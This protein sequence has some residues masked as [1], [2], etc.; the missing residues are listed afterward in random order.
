MSNKATIY[1]VSTDD[2]KEGVRRCLSNI[3]P[4]DY[5]GKTLFVKP[6]FNT[7]DITP[8]SSHNDTIEALLIGLKAARPLSITLGDRSGPAD[9]GDVMRQKEMPELCAKYGVKLVNFEELK[10]DEWV[11]FN[12]E[13]L[14][15]PYGFEMPKLVLESDVIIA[16]CCLKTHAFGGVFSSSLKLGIGFTQKDFKTLHTCDIRQMIAEVN[17]AYKPDFI[18]MD[19]IDV[20]TDGGPMEGTRAKAD[21]M[22]LGRDR[23]AIDAVGLAILKHVGSN[24]EIMDT[25]IFKQ[26]QITRAIELGLGVTG[27]DE[28]EIVTADPESEAYAVKI[29]AI[30][31]AEN[32]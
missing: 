32:K 15:W 30:L 18:L 13:D 26:E 21:V 11:N 16:T 24:K 23:I 27:P 6:N 4:L 9:T 17:L 1:L 29:R 5:T 25:P 3:A 20:F 19:G 22:L 7:A 2:R 8:G 12:R 28:I 14:H 31:R 10:P